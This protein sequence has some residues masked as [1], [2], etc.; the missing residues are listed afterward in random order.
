MKKIKKITLKNFGPIKEAD[1]ELGDITILVGPQ[2]TGKSLF[3]QFLNLVLDYASIKKKLQKNALIVTNKEELLEHY[4]GK[5]LAKSWVENTEISENDSKVDI[6]KFAKSRPRSDEP[7]TFYMPAQRVLTM[8][9][10]WPRTIESLIIY[11][12]VVRDFSERL[13]LLMESGLGKGEA[14]FPPEGRFKKVITEKLQFGIFRNTKVKVGQELK[15]ELVLEVKGID[16]QSL[17]LP[18]PFWSAGQR[19]FMPLL[20]GLYYLAPGSRV[21]TKREIETVIIEEI[22]MGLH[23]DAILGVMLAVMELINR[24][25]RVVIS[26]HSIHVVEIIWAIERIKKSKIKNSEK[27]RFFINDLFKVND[28][29]VDIMQMAEECLRKIYKV[30]YFEPELSTGLT[31]ARDISS[32]EPFDEDAGISGWGGLSGFSSSIVDV[33][34]QLQED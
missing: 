24:G 11:P 20:L 29:R 30:F 27:K 5:A 10:G 16:N 7:N 12:Y 23:P 8:E 9:N 28:N 21:T 15:K 31:V 3:L 2:A 14:L 1:V 25:Y 33:V 22:E 32:L 13:R 6:D 26:T 19:E 18:I 34:S 4:L 17:K